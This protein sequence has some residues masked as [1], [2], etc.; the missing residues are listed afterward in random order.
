MA[1]NKILTHLGSSHLADET[2][3]V[4]LFF[5]EKEIWK[6]IPNYVGIY[7]VSNLGR[8]KR[9]KRISVRNGIYNIS[10]KEKILTGRPCNKGY[11]RCILTKN[12]IRSEFKIHRLVAQSFLGLE[13]NDK[14]IF[15]DHINFNK[16]D[17]SVDNLRLSNARMN[18]Q[19]KVGNKI[20]LY[21]SKYVGVYKRSDS[22]LWASN[23]GLNNKKIYLGSFESEEDAAKAYDKECIKNGLNP[24]N[25]INHVNNK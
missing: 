20:G 24:V 16:K 25:I 23:I 18:S 8:V 4:F 21:T 7:Q 10:L 15:I 9:L 22:D 6:D 5:M 14:N 11:L 13:I 17:N 2:Q 12:K 19:H 3:C 1:R